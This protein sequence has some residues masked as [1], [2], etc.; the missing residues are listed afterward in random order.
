[1]KLQDIATHESEDEE[2]INLTPLLDVLFVVLILFI[3]IAPLLDT[4]R[5]ELAS[6]GAKK[7]I[8]PLEQ[9]APLKIYVDRENHIWFNQAAITLKE[10]EVLAEKIQQR[11]PEEIPQIYH[12]KNAAFGTYL[13]IKTVLE[14]AGFA[15]MDIV[16][17][18]G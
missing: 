16:L 12:D 8:L 11:F 17:K 5:V 7:E 6:K 3:L 1:M 13:A 14:N 2:L 15:T 9:H 18:N 4:D 10:L